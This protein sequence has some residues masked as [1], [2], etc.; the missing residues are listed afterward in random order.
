MNKQSATKLIHNFSDSILQSEE[1]KG[2]G[3]YKY[4]TLTG[5]L[6]IVLAESFVNKTK[7]LKLIT[8]KAMTQDRLSALDLLHDFN[9]QV[10]LSQ[11][12]LPEF[13]KCREILQNAADLAVLSG[14]PET[15]FF[16]VDVLERYVINYCL[17]Y[18][19]PI[20]EPEEEI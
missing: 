4:Q 5:E 13:I 10:T 7:A 6:E 16:A 20:A 12:E 18:M 14:I 3:A 19:A 15:P 8:P 9:E 17:G 2:K 11:S 1:S